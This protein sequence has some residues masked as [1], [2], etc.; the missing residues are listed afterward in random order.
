MIIFFIS[1]SVF[2]RESGRVGNFLEKTFKIGSYGGTSTLDLGKDCFVRFYKPKLRNAPYGY[3]TH[4]VSIISHDRISTVSYRLN[5]TRL[6]GGRGDFP[7][8]SSY[9]NYVYIMN[10]G[11][12][13]LNFGNP[14]RVNHGG[15]TVRIGDKVNIKVLNSDAEIIGTCSVDKSILKD[16]F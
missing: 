13:P 3:A 12:R 14:R 16:N 1:S 6:N 4:V 10:N 11:G 5:E 15:L 9:F 8:F 2:A 7:T